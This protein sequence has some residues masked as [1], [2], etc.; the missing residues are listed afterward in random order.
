M[1]VVTAYH[2]YFANADIAKQ[3]LIVVRNLT[4]DDDNRVLFRPHLRTVMDCMTHHLHTPHNPNRNIALQGSVAMYNLSIDYENS[5]IMA[6]IGV[7]EM[8]QSMVMDN[9]LAG[10]DDSRKWASKTI[11]FLNNPDA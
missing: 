10:D 2:F 4:A 6:E 3:G 8:L 5:S 7:R 11:H 1:I 9:P